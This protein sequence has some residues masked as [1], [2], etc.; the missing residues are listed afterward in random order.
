MVTDGT[1]SSHARTETW[2]GEKIRALTDLVPDEMWAMSVGINPSTVSVDAGH[3]YQGTLGKRH[4]GRLRRAGLLPDEPGWEDDL[5]MSVGIGFSDV[6]K[7]PTAGAG[8]LDADDWEH[9]TKLLARKLKK[10]QPRLVIFTFGDAGTAMVPG[11]T[12]GRHRSVALEGVEDAFLMPGPYARTEFVDEKIAE[13]KR[14]VR[15]LCR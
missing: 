6:I 4:W 15:R 9:G 1:S 13:L 8:E 10:W 7:R 2:R 11:I 5:S 12:P 14:A 3:Y